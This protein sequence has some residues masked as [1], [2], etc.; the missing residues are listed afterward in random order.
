MK[1]VRFQI[2]DEAL[3]GSYEGGRLVGPDGRVFD[4]GTVRWLPPLVPGTIIGLL[5]GS[6]NQEVERNLTTL[7]GAARRVHADRP[8]TRFLVACYR[9]EH[10]SQVE[11][12]LRQF[13]LPI[14]AHAGR[15][16]EIIH[17]AKA[18]VAG[19]P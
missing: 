1:R 3:S 13:D 12:R 6:R 14:E 19:L 15:T 9:D 18:T 11:E 8:E 7:L 17:L 4:E 2:G 5:P 10:K 16:A